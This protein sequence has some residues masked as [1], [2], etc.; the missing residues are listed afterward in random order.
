MT[1]SILTILHRQNS[2]VCGKKKKS[3]PTSSSVYSSVFFFSLCQDLPH[4][5]NCTNKRVLKA[6]ISLINCC[7]DCEPVYQV[8]WTS[9]ESSHQ[10]FLDVQF[11]TWLKCYSFFLVACSC[12]PWSI[13][14]LFAPE[15][16][17]AWAS[18]SLRTCFVVQS[19]F[20]I[21][22]AASKSQKSA[23]VSSSP[24]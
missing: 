17:P 21:P 1:I 19:W 22:N 16:S 12:Q 10:L 7:F 8:S 13:R 20:L 3:H 23:S 24:Q 2:S 11:V 15:F 4:Q 14:S 5:S 6:W 9:S 18:F